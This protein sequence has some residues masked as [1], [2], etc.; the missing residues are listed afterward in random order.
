LQ[1]A[2]QLQAYF[3]E[4]RDLMLVCIQWSLI[5]MKTEMAVFMYNR[6]FLLSLPGI[7][8]SLCNGVSLFKYHCNN[9]C[10]L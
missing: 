5:L 6:V 8:I 3:D 1:Q 4:Y 9:S 7:C 2:E 10:R